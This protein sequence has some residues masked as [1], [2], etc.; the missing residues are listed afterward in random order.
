MQVQSTERTLKLHDKGNDV[1]HLQDDLNLLGY[2]LLTVD[3]DFGSKTQAAVK[4]FQTDND[5]DVDG[6]VG[7]KTWEALHEQAAAK[8]RAG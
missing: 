6:I 2:G 1:K 4:S 7:P 5:L 8:R 3:G